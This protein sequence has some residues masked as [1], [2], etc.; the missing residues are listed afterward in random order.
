MT[1][2]H[3]THCYEVH[4]AKGENIAHARVKEAPGG[5][6]LTDV[7]CHADYRRQGKAARPRPAAR[8][9]AK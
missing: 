8:G 5:L 9:A 2:M 6:W 1:P 4:D 7:W 3:V